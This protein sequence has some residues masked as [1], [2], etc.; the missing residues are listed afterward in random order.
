MPGASDLKTEISQLK[1]ETDSKRRSR[2][3]RPR[4]PLDETAAA[5]ATED[6]DPAEPS[7]HPE[8]SN[9]ADR[10]SELVEEAGDE[11]KER[12]VTA[13]LG[14]FALGVVVGALL[15]R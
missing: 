6:A 10:L 5:P 13:V 2:K 15:R 8:I 4:K 11:I 12:P 1:A 14:A 7:A 3:P 9:L